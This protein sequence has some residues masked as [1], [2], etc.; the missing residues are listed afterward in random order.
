[1]FNVTDVVFHAATQT[2]S[3]LINRVVD[4]GLLH[5]RPRCDQMRVRYIMSRVKLMTF[6]M[7]Q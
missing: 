1:M 5:T 7:I 4:N 2:F 6:L 3:P